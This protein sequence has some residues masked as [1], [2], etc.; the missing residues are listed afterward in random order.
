MRKKTPFI[1]LAAGGHAKVLLSL[2]EALVLP[3]KGVCDPE[4]AKQGVTSW[5]GLAVLGGDEILETLKPKEVFLI[6]GI[7]QTVGNDARQQL[8][9]KLRG[10]GFSFPPLVHPSAFVARKTKLADGVQ[11]M[12]GAMIQ[13]DCTIGENTIVNTRASIDHDVTIGAH[14]HIAPGATLCG[15]AYISDGAF[16]AAGSIVGPGVRVGNAAVLGAG[17]ALVR[18]LAD[19]QT[20]IG[21]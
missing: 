3:I 10:K 17:A 21:K 20:F 18:N 1:L 6:N 16:I 14:V 13:P 5:R 9:I 19:N 4:L 12:A 8:Y 15:N 2:A 7:G 11:V